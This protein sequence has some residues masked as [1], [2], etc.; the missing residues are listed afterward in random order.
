MVAEVEGTTGVTP[1]ALRRHNQLAFLQQEVAPED[2]GNIAPPTLDP[3]VHVD[4]LR[5]SLLGSDDLGSV[6]SPSVAT[7]HEGP[8]PECTLVVVGDPREDKEDRVQELQR[9]IVVERVQREKQEALRIRL[10]AKLKETLEFIETHGEHNQM[11]KEAKSLDSIEEVV[12]RIASCKSARK[13]A[14]GRSPSCHLRQRLDRL[15]SEPARPTASASEA[16]LPVQ[17]QPDAGEDFM[18]VGDGFTHRFPTPQHVENLRCDREVEPRKH[19][20]PV[21][22][23]HHGVAPAAFPLSIHHGRPAA[24][25]GPQVRHGVAFAASVPSIHHAQPP[26]A[27]APSVHRTHR[28]VEKRMEMEEEGA[29]VTSSMHGPQSP[30]QEPATSLRWWRSS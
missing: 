26:A 30:V 8:K 29:A 9:F 25:S 18:A 3:E 7:A 28:V 17:P 13:D 6:V 5:R 24:P 16:Q 11:A 12:C 20:D 19:P 22:Q 23:V 10:E 21:H 15:G 4:I 1:E 2:L 14:H 27:S